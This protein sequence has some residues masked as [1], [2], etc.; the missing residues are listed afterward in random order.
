MHTQLIN[1]I[2]RLE[3][4]RE[5]RVL[6][7]FCGGNKTAGGKVIEDEDLPPLYAVC[8]KLRTQL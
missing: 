6:V 5:S 3:A 7:Y 8:Q 1:E 4:L 2:S